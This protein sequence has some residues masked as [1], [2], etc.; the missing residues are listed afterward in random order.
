MSIPQTPSKEM[1]DNSTKDHNTTNDEYKS[2]SVADLNNGFYEDAISNLNIY[3]SAHPSDIETRVLLAQS[4]YDEGDYDE[5]INRCNLIL[6][7]NPDEPSALVLR[8]CCFMYHRDWVNA[9]SDF[10]KCSQIWPTNDAPFSLRAMAYYH[11]HNYAEAIETITKS[12]QIKTNN[13]NALLLRADACGS[14]GRYNQAIADYVSAI[15]CDTNNFNAYNDYAWF[16][17]TCLN[18]SLRD[19]AASIQ[20]ARAACGLTS[21]KRWE[22][23]DTLAVAYAESG[24]FDSALMIENL[25]RNLQGDSTVDEYL[26]QQR[27]VSFKEHKMPKL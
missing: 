11:Q 25:A 9:I 6:Q 4:F 20:M 22:C 7:Q 19:A 3:C 17:A 26:I 16:R 10:E 18:R 13:S 21:W 8:G 2:H 14:S 15:S 24:D 5:T 27:I 23:I 12:L 1:Q